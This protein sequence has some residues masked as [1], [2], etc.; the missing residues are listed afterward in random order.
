MA[1]FIW[2]ELAVNIEAINS[3]ELLVDKI[4][5]MIF[6]RLLLL[7]ISK[8]IQDGEYLSLMLNCSHMIS[9]LK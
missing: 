8:N 1:I 3:F 2:L 4:G 9:I 7:F 5:V 6:T